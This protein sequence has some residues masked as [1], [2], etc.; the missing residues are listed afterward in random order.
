LWC[1][2]R[3]NT[4]GFYERFGLRPEGDIFYKGPIAY[5][6]LRLALS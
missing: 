2:A 1:D 3:Q 5:V 4:L 6:R